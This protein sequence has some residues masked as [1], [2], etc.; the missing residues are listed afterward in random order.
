MLIPMFSYFTKEVKRNILKVYNEAKGNY[1][2]LSEKPKK[3]VVI[4]YNI[5]IAYQLIPSF[6]VLL[7]SWIVFIKISQGLLLVENISAFMC[8]LVI[9]MY[10]IYLF[11]LSPKLIYWLHQ[12]KY[13][14]SDVLIFL[15]TLIQIILFLLFVI[16]L[17]KSL[18]M[19]NLSFNLTWD[20]FW[21]FLGFGI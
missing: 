4:Y 9:T 8:G 21:N 12:L 18:W 14:N 11:F 19:E 2:L 10:V 13:G 6:M 20:S 7:I 15:R 5:F 1:A 16:P 17:S 3:Y